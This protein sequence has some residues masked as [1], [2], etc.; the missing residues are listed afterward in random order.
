MP[1]PSTKIM[2]TRLENVLKAQE[3]HIAYPQKN[4]GIT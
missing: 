1:V 4:R 3:V 2:T